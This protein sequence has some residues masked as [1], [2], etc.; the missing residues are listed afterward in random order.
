MTRV[1]FT[2]DQL[3]EILRRHPRA[4]A[5]AV[6]RSDYLYIRLGPEDAPKLTSRVMTTVEGLDLVLDLDE[7]GKVYGLELH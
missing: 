6:D 7:R 3:R 1:D 4:A 2:L 5:W